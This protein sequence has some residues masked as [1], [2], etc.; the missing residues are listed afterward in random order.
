[1]CWRVGFLNAARMSSEAVTTLPGRVTTPRPPA[2]APKPLVSFELSSSASSAGLSSSFAASLM[3]PSFTSLAMPLAWPAPSSTTSD[4]SLIA[5][6]TSPTSSACSES[7]RARV[8]KLAP[9][10]ASFSKVS[11]GAS[12][13]ALA[14]SGVSSAGCS[15]GRVEG[16]TDPSLEIVAMTPPLSQELSGELRN[17][18]R[19]QPTGTSGEI[20]CIAGGLDVQTPE[21]LVGLEHQGRVIVGGRGPVHKGFVHRARPTV[22]S[23]ENHFRFLVHLLVEAEDLEPVFDRRVRI[24]EIA[25]DSQ[26]LLP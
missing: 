19:V 4:V 24:R 13:P 7:L 3:L 22:V 9:R 8:I 5:S 20:R 21:L 6:P 12:V 17:L 18:A 25:A 16:A 1:M 15:A 11:F 10:I 26:H 14:A 23:G 2:T